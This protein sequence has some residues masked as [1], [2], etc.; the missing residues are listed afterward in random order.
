M[1]EKGENYPDQERPQRGLSSVTIN[2]YLVDLWWG[3]S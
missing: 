3:K 2:Q 1:E